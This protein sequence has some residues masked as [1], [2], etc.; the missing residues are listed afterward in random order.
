MGKTNKRLKQCTVCNGEF[1]D[2]TRPNNKKTCSKECGN[3]AKNDKRR[4]E[5]R[6]ENPYKPNQREEFYYSHYEYSFWVDNE[7]GR[8][9]SW[10][11]DV[12]YSPDK[13]ESIASAKEI[14]EYHGGRK[15]RQEVVEYDG[16]EQGNHGVRVKFAESDQVPSEVTSYTMSPEELKAYLDEKKSCKF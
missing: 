4:V 15:R 11:E 3:V 8:N 14:Y 7:I 12:P 10:K 9:Q 5:Y 2:N 6:Q 1:K 16:D 13:I